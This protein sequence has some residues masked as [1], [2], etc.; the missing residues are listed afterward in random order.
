M[1]CGAIAH[2]DKGKVVKLKGDPDYFTKGFFCD[3]RARYI[4]Y[5]YHPDRK[6]YPDPTVEIH[7]DTA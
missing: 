6:L 1:Q 7:P 3:R 4:G 5:L 2:V